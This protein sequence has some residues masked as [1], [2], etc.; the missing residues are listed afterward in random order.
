MAIN[1]DLTKSEIRILESAFAGDDNLEFYLKQIP[2]LKV[3]ERITADG[4]YYVCLSEKSLVD[5]KVPRGFENIVIMDLF[6]SI[7]GVHE[8]IP[9]EVCTRHGAIKSIDLMGGES[10]PSEFVISK[11]YWKN[12]S[13]PDR[14]KIIDSDQRDLQSGLAY[15][16]TY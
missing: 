6:L 9:V 7:E 14:N 2:M 16:P 13:T 15:T 5:N 3:S 10:I 11:I 1:S 4:G 8:E 12:L